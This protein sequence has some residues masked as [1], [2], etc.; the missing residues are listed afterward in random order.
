[1]LKKFTIKA[2]LVLLIGFLILMILLKGWQGGAS[3]N[4]AAKSL[5]ELYKESIMTSHILNKLKQLYGDKIP[6]TLQKMRDDTISW[7]DGLHIINENRAMIA[8][9]WEQYLKLNLDP[10]E[11]KLADETSELIRN[12]N[13]SLDKLK[14]INS[15]DEVKLND[16]ISKEFHSVRDPVV[17][18]INKLTQLDNDGTEQKFQDT[19]DFINKLLMFSILTTILALVISIPFGYAVSR[20]IFIPLKQ[21]VTAVNQLAVGNTDVNLDYDS[22]DQ[23]AQLFESMKNMVSSSD[24]MISVLSAV[25]DGDLTVSVEPRSEGDTLGHALNNMV[26]KL[27]Q[28]LGEIQRE[29]K[30]L[31]N[32]TEEIVTSVTHA[33]AGTTE[34]AAAVT[35]TTSTVEE[36][37]QTS[38]LAFEKA[39]GVHNCSMET[40]NIVNTC[41]QSLSGTIKDMIE[42]QTKMEIISDCIIKLSEHSIAIGNIVDSVNDL[43]EQSNLLAVNAA[44]EAARV[45]EQGRGFGVVAQEIRA[46]AEQSKEAT[47]Q[48]RNILQDIQNATN[49]AVMATEQGTKA[50]VKGVNQSHQT[51]DSMRALTESFTDVAS[52]ATQISSSSKQQL[53]AIDQVTT[54]ILQINQASSQQSEIMQQ[55]KSAVINLNSVGESVN[56]LTNQYQITIDTKNGNKAVSKHLQHYIASND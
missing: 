28:M 24:K 55:I 51:N 20:S 43:A 39:D 34:T 8:T 5:K 2:R 36:L 26:I 14:T 1:M 18:N 56:N 9:E 54:A 22:K 12:S 13:L 50:V 15:K 49:N 32:Y 10:K 19:L 17:D 41:E 42:I 23:I 53:I 16:Y 6:N 3:I 37:K 21:A 38:T 30:A 25:S 48:I 44:I 27:R 35:E 29:M 4:Y 52:A 11:L 46:L 45:G 40:M 7:D 47:S 33:S 31:R